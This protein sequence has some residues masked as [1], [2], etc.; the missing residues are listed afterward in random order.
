VS[1]RLA[2]EVFGSPP[3]LISISVCPKRSMTVRSADAHAERKVGRGLS[4]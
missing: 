4:Q 1:E 2:P 3:S